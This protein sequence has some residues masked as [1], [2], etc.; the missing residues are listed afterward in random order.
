MVSRRPE[1][2]WTWGKGGEG[3]AESGARK[4]EGKVSQERVTYVGL[5]FV[6]SD[7]WI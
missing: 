3:M 4:R 1:Q 6:L 2:R 5:E 7:A